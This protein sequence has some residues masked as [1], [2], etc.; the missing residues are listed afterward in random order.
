MYPAICGGDF[1]GPRWW[2]RRRRKPRLLWR[3]QS[4]FSRTNGRRLRRFRKPGRLFRRRKL[5]RPGRISATPAAPAPEQQFRHVH[6][7]CART[8]EPRFR[9]ERRRFRPQ[10]AEKQR[11]SHGGSDGH[12]G[13]CC[14]FDCGDAGL[15]AFGRRPG[16]R[17][18]GVYGSAGGAAGR[19]GERDGL[20][21][22]RAG[23]DRKPH[24]AGSGHEKLL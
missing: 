2:S 24:Q 13:H 21:Y 18:Y 22:R 8:D 19:G 17:R 11:M 4:R 1:Y 23:L 6:R 9:L 12:C 15:F 5:W 3:R 16:L 10:P 20:L 7:L 14:D